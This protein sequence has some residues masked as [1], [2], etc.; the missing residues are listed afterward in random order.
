MTEA[1][2]DFDVLEHASESD[3]QSILPMK[4]PRFAPQNH[5][6]KDLFEGKIHM[7]S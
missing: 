4:A 6:V 1:F 2:H 5:S 7:G 3:H